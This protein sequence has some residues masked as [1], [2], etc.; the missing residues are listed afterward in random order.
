MMESTDFINQNPRSPILVK[1]PGEDGSTGSTIDQ[2]MPTE[3]AIEHGVNTLVNDVVD[4]AL[5]QVK[6]NQELQLVRE[7]V[8]TVMGD[9][10]KEIAAEHPQCQSPLATGVSPMN[11][12][13]TNT[14][15]S[16]VEC[17]IS[18]AKQVQELG[19]TEFTAGLI[20]SA[21][22][23]IMGATIK[24]MEAYRELVANLAKTLAQFQAEN[25][26]DAQITDHL[27]QHY[28]DGPGGTVVRPNYTFK[29]I[30]ANPNTGTQ[31]KPANHL[32][33]EVAQ[34]LE[35][36]T[37]NLTNPLTLTIQENQERFFTSQVQE[38]RS[39]IGELLA[40]N[41][42]EHLRAIA[43]EGMARIVV[44]DGEIVSKLTF[45]VTATEQQT[46]GTNQ[47][48][49]QHKPQQAMQSAKGGFPHSLSHQETSPYIRG[50]AVAES[51][52]VS[53]GTSHNKLTVKPVNESSFDAVTMSTDIIGQVKIR[54][55]TETFP[56]VDR[57]R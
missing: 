3:V 33:R 27:V 50:R 45:N 52:N 29:T 17:G 12:N 10:L 46:T 23:A 38:I 24:Q 28:P 20:N 8:A 53:A 22:D 32:L 4:Q 11:N 41:M 34:A 30:P 54:F 43:R 26:S 39:K 49:R 48:Q 25:V 19:F 16:A 40:T 6:S 2:S 56:P 36:E 9:T 18:G 47:Y 57:N 51:G 13:N 5:V 44:T 37:I 31:E 7:K 14:N 1:M 15:N 42:I 21:F 55:K 35:A